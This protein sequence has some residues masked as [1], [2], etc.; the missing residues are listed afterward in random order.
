MQRCNGQHRCQKIE[1][2]PLGER[3]CVRECFW[4]SV[5]VLRLSGN[6][7]QKLLH[8]DPW[9]LINNPS[10][11]LITL[12]H[13]LSSQIFGGKTQNS[14]SHSHKTIKRLFYKLSCKRNG[15]TKNEKIS[16][17]ISRHVS[18]FELLLVCYRLSIALDTHVVARS[19][20][21]CNWEQHG[22]PI[23]FFEQQPL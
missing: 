14:K 7:H 21:I 5:W 8:G 11:A 15:S 18:L 17:Q 6:T 1:Y 2:A 12:T 19:R 23:Q 9:G 22:K 4:S 16:R 20:C 10:R 3:A 13:R